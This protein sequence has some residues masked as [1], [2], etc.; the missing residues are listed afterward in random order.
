MADRLHIATIL[1]AHGVRGLVRVRVHA[2]D[3]AL[4]D[5]PLHTGPE[6]GATLTLALKNPHGAPGTWLA[7]VEGADG[8]QGAQAL[9]GTRLYIPRTALPEA[10]DGAY[11]YTDLI[12]LAAVDAGDGA[13]VGRVAAVHDF[14]AGDLLEVA[15]P[16]GPAFLVPFTHAHVPTVDI[17]GGRVV[18]AGW[19]DFVDNPGA[20]GQDA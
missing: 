14:G 19:R 5:G 8:R 13:P 16:D 10:G 12:G 18:L 2:D 4:A 7:A 20:G 11:Y 9:A 3:P 15:P 17:P 1:G 6:G